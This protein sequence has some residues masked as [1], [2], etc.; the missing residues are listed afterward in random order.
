MTWDD[1]RRSVQ[2]VSDL[3]DSQNSFMRHG[4]S[5]RICSLLPSG[6]EIVFALDLGHQLVAVTHECEVPAR[7]GTIPIVTRSTIDQAARGSRDIH[8]HVTE[9]LHRGSSIYSLDIGCQK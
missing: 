1:P 5:M 2:L 6:T 3:L 9:A 7:A 4:G 8:N